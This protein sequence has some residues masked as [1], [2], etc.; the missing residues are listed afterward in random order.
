MKIETL[1]VFAWTPK[2]LLCSISSLLKQVT[3]IQ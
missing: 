2:P 1:S 3:A